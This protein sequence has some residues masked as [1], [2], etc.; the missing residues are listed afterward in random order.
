MTKRLFWILLAV[1]GLSYGIQLVLY[2]RLPTLVPTTWGV[3]GQITN[4][5][6]KST[7]LIL[8]ALPAAFV[9]LFQLL[10]KLD[11]RS[12]NYHRHQKAYNAMGLVLAL[13]MLF[14][15]WLV[16]LAS[17]GVHLPVA[18]FLIASIG[19]TFAVM[20]NYMPQVRSNFFMGFRTPWALD[21]EDVWRKTH[22]LAG[23]L[24]F[25]W[26][27]LIFVFAFLPLNWAM[28]AVLAGAAVFIVVPTIYSYILYRKHKNNTSKEEP[29]AKN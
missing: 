7:N 3:T 10:P 17:L 21:D 22:R 1:C 25:I 15:T 23:I 18:R 6:P 26:G 19:I 5:G 16:T 8:G 9:L 27:A 14:F 29:H 20:G 13:M 24:F 11:P 4:W 12:E 2:P 28:W